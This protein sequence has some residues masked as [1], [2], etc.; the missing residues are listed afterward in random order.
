MRKSY[1]FVAAA[2]AATVFGMSSMASAAYLSFD[3]QGD[4]VGAAPSGTSY[5]LA[6]GTNRLEVVDSASNPAD[7]FGG[8]GNK[9]LLL[10]DNS[11]PLPGGA[12][13]EVRFQGGAGAP[14]AGTFSTN[15]YAFDD[16]TYHRPFLEVK[17]GTNN[18]AS[19]GDIG[20]WLFFTDSGTISD[21]NGGPAFDNVLTLNTINT[22][23]LTFDTVADTYS[24]TIQQGAGPAVPLTKDSGA[25]T[26]FSL[27]T[28]PS[29]GIDSVGF[30]VGWSS[31]AEDRQFVDNVTITAVPEPASMGLILGAGAMMLRRRNCGQM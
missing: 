6:G 30:G 1:K 14:T 3:F 29:V 9:S 11:D 24:G 13:A 12:S 26:V 16:A 28:A 23:T 7:P 27:G 4:T 17:L 31:N 21:F 15:F 22:L 20:A 5:A 10:E 8:S 19:G 2:T 25:T 18:V